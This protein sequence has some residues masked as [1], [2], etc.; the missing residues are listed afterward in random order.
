MVV[1]D[2]YARLAPRII[3]ALDTR[4]R[5]AVELDDAFL[6]SIRE[7]GI[8]TPLLVSHDGERAILV[9]G[10]RRLAAAIELALP[11]VPVRYVKPGLSAEDIELIELEENI[12]R[13]DL[14]WQDEVRAV[15]RLH[16]MWSARDAGWNQA[17]SHA[18]LGHQMPVY[19]RVARALSDPREC[20]KIAH[21][22]GIRAAWNICARI[23]ERTHDAVLD[24]ISGAF[25]D[26]GERYTKEEL[27]T[28]PAPT[29]SGGEGQSSPLDG[30][31]ESSAARGSVVVGEPPSAQDAA[32]GDGAGPSVPASPSLRGRSGRERYTPL[33]D[34]VVGDFREWSAA[35]DG[36]KFNFLH[37]DFPYGKR[38]FAGAQ[39][40]KSSEEEFK[41]DDEPSTYWDLCT[42]LCSALDR[43]LSPTSHVMFWL[44]A[45][46][47]ML[48]ETIE[49]FRTHAPSLLFSRRALIWHKS[50]NA[51]IVTDVRRAPRWTYETALFAS[52][53][54]RVIV[55]PVAASYAAPT[56]RS[57]HPSVKPEPMLRHFFSMFVDDT[58]RM[59][60]PT[61]GA[62]S[63][64][65][66]AESLG[67]ERVMGIERSAE[68]AATAIRELRA[69]RALAEIVG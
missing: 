3:R 47:S 35:Y 54:D 18:V 62:G 45:D 29:T 17:K 67:A 46:I 6:A 48:H 7:R 24:E 66:A 5:S 49:F 10:G 37:C 30:E 40:G 16:T 51:G 50:D 22:Q 59:L 12:R 8:M 11:D 1:T 19:L 55:K 27:S 57:A 60:D 65:R 44:S 14:S 53:G 9:A 15:E 56:A 21:A 28:I 64:L 13:K 63:A 38:V 4:Q 68:F 61:C 52:R 42:A 2:Q 36:P 34:V 58:T 25:S 32:S 41:Y 20:E 23:D 39:G 69:F 31:G 33:D 43:L 26:I